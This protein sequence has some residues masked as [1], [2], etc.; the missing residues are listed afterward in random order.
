MQNIVPGIA[1]PIIRNRHQTEPAKCGM[2]MEEMGRTPTPPWADQR[3]LEA[4]AL[5]CSPPRAKAVRQKIERRA[6]RCW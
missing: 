6:K 2:K 5:G 4:G 1:G 3:L